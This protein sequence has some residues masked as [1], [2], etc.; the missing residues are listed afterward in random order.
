[1]LPQEGKLKTFFL[2]VFVRLEKKQKLCG[3]TMSLQCGAQ[4]LWSIVKAKRDKFPNTGSSKIDILSKYRN[5]LRLLLYESFGRQRN[6]R[7]KP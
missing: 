1:V 2:L 4:R 5:Q 7:R 6:G 3:H